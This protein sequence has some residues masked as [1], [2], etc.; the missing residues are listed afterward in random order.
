MKKKQKESES[1]YPAEKVYIDA[2]LL[3][4]AASD[5][6]EHGEKAIKILEKIKDEFYKPY[7]AALTI[8]EVMWIVQKERGRELALETANATLSIPSLEIVAVDRNIM[9]NTLIAYKEEKLNPRDAIHLATMRSKKISIIIS[10]DSDFDN[11]NDIKRIDFTK[12]T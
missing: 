2:S 6:D 9:K 5:I 7:T 4:S 10:S 12:V 8:D 3:I 1:K 11:I